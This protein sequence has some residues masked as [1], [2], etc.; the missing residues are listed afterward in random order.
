MPKAPF[1]FPAWRH[2]WV[3]FIAGFVLSV[4]LTIA[5]KSEYG[6]DSARLIIALWLQCCLLAMIMMG[7]LNW[8]LSRY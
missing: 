2:M 6:A 1:W 3:R 5:F 8:L 7:G 4:L